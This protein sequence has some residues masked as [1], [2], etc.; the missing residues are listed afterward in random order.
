M[1][2]VFGGEFS[3]TGGGANN[4]WDNSSNW[5]LDS[6]TDDNSNGYPDGADNATINATVTLTGTIGCTDFT[7]SGGTVTLGASST[8]SNDVSVSS[9][10]TLDINGNTCDIGGDATIDGDLDDGTFTTSRIFQVAGNLAV[11]GTIYYVSVIFDG[12]S[13]QVISGTGTFQFYY[14][15]FANTGGAG[16]EVSNSSASQDFTQVI[17]SDGS[18]QP[19]NDWIAASV[20]ATTATRL[21][22]T[23]GSLT[24]QNPSKFI[25]TGTQTV[26]PP[27][28]ATIT[29]S[30][31]ASTPSTTTF[32][33]LEFSS[34]SAN[35]V[36]SF[37]NSNSASYQI[38]GTFEFTGS[39]KGS[40]STSNA[41]ITYGSSG[42]IKYSVGGT[43]D[44]D[45]WP[46]GGVP[47]VVLQNGS[48]TIPSGTFEV[49]NKLTRING[50]VSL[51]GT[52]QYDQSNVTTL[53]YTPSPASSVT[54]GG[55]WPST[56]GPSNVTINNSSNTVTSNSSRQVPRTLSM[57]AGTLAMGSNDLTILGTLAGSDLADGGTVTSSG[58]ITLGNGTGTG[59]QENQTISGNVR[60]SNLTIN[61]DDSDGSNTVTVSGSP[62]IT[63]DFIVSNGDVIANG[64]VTISSG[65]L[66]LDNAST[67]TVNT[68]ALDVAT[69]DLNNTAT[70]TTGGK[71]ITNISTITADDET[72]FEFNGTTVETTPLSTL[73]LGHINMNNTAGLNINGSVTVNGTVTFNQDATINTDATNTLLIS[74]GGSIAGNN[75]SRFVN[76]PLRKAF[77]S[78]TQSF[79]F[80]VGYS[81]TYHPA[82][83]DY[84]TNSV[85]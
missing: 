44:A 71:Q 23:G 54:I 9:G 32:H 25:F 63:N 81:S 45:E 28:P 84:L 76:G 65:T 73:T 52:L 10:A 12:S 66:Q 57:T 3:W 41:T 19:S 31:T 33:N 38:N 22:I 82:V 53:E 56:N 74:S 60:L 51:T 35:N 49:D 69:M 83:F 48:I 29:I 6:G 77:A 40:I 30:N 39:T 36:L 11:D 8:F 5:N 85:S 26:P 16:T 17:V 24:A 62:V 75:G 72:T 27:S 42:T 2:N 43:V 7:V 78:G 70:Y 50:S 37:S 55:E 14:V 59:N 80:P 46:S 79:T 68:G 58:T 34:N 47:N 21:S 4:D 61:K 13:D 1:G 18:F 64:T 20:S 67:F 15:E